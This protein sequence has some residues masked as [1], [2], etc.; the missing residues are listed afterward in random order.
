MIRNI[1]YKIK[2]V[3][4]IFL[5]KHLTQCTNALI[6]WHVSMIINVFFMLCI[7]VQSNLYQLWVRFIVTL[8]FLLTFSQQNDSTVFHTIYMI[9]VSLLIFLLI[10]ILSITEYDFHVFIFNLCSTIKQPFTLYRKQSFYAT[11]NKQLNE[12]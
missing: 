7:L 6:L 5:L 3:Y 12:K 9:L 2:C 10:S 11:I 1:H 8:Y 4:C